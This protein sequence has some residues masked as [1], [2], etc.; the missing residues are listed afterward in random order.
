M[1]DFDELAHNQSCNTTGKVET[2]PLFLCKKQRTRGGSRRVKG[3]S[4]A[5]GGNC[6]ERGKKGYGNEGFVAR[7]WSLGRML[8]RSAQA[9]AHSSFQAHLRAKQGKRED[10]A[11]ME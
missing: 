10:G 1:S 8:G 7:P 3:G 4:D 9:G 6:S 2:K 11:R 5:S